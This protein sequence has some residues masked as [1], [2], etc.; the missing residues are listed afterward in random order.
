MKR[1][2]LPKII[3]ITVALVLCMFNTINAQSFI[4]EF[5]D[6]HECV[7][8]GGWVRQN[9][10][11]PIGTNNWSYSDSIQTPYGSSYSAATATSLSVNTAG[12]ISNWFFTPVRELRTGD[13]LRFYTKSL[14]NSV[15][16]DRLEVR[17]SLSGAGIHI[18]SSTSV[19]E[20]DNL[21]L[22]VN[23]TLQGGN[24]YPNTWTLYTAVVPHLE[25]PTMG[26]FAFR[27]FV[28]GAGNNQPGTNA[29][30]IAI[31][32]VEY[33]Q[34][35]YNAT[36][37]NIMSPVAVECTNF[38]APH[39]RFSN[40][41]I[42]TVDS[43]IFNFRFNTDDYQL[44]SWAGE[45]APNATVD[46]DMPGR[47]CFPGPNTFELEILKVNDL[48]AYD[49]DAVNFNVSEVPVLELGNAEA[50]C[51]QA[52]INPALTGVTYAWSDNS[53]AA[54]LNVTQS[55]TYNLT[56]TNTDGCTATDSKQITINPLPQ[57]TVSAP[58][59]AMCAS[60]APTL[61]NASPVGGTFTGNG[62]TGN[63][64]TPSASLVGT[65]VI[66]Y[67]YTDANGCT[68]TDNESVIINPD[69]II[70][71]SIGQDSICQGASAISL[72]ATP[73]GG[74]FSGAGITGTQFIPSVNLQGNN[75]ITYTYTDANGC[76]A[77]AQDNLHV[78]DCSTVITPTGIND[79]VNNVSISV[80]PNPFFGNA[81]IL[82]ILD[83]AS[84]V[85][86]D[87]YDVQGRLITNLLNSVEMASGVNRIPVDGSNLPEGMYVLKLKAGST[88][89]NIKLYHSNQ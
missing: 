60:A 56:V 62:L 3:F 31:D 17:L 59:T 74:T 75:T 14:K 89:K 85:T 41:G 8:I 84:D 6:I 66:T 64:F 4:E 16:P 55:G 33:K 21:L 12:T 83:K 78:G 7:T 61:L 70:Y 38:I 24:A 87:L 11:D 73:V 46:I 42:A 13:T 45:V 69:P 27:Y 32:K 9:H 57:V 81:A 51:G 82:V 19:G 35:N 36:V 77:S 86:A 44:W 80:Y 50:F 48:A 30:M 43:I 72:N 68:N 5:E 26:R 40:A 58:Q 79:V 39:F 1:I 20:F 53:T 2:I 23:P 76:T 65:N 25:A 22:T 49:Y 29:S 18:T 47:Y 37:S 63:Q 34:V 28:T 10:S 67:T 54:T 88:A 52:T 71:F 15:Y